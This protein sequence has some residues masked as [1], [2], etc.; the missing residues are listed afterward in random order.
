M[1]TDVLGE[2]ITNKISLGAWAYEESNCKEKLLD[3]PLWITL[4]PII[5]FEVSHSINDLLVFLMGLIHVISYCH[6][7][8]FFSYNILFVLMI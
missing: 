4:S 1:N 7:I 8:I 6:S 2:T 3:L 5:D